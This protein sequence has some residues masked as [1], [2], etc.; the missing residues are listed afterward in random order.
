MLQVVLQTGVAAG[1]K[2]QKC[3]AGCEC[4]NCL[5]VTDVLEAE[6]EMMDI[7]LEENCT[8]YQDVDDIM[9]SVFGTDQEGQE[10]SNYEEIDSDC[11][12]S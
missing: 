10:G 1:K 5:N 7:E 9:D 8:Q 2:N 11:S 12:E 4:T 3:S 6:S